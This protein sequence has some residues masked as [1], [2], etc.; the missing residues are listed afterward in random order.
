MTTL[1]CTDCGFDASHWSD[2]DLGRTLAHADD[3]I[4]YVLEGADER[5]AADVGAMPV[6][7]SGDPITSAHAVMHRLHEAAAVR[8]VDGNFEPMVGRVA[9]LQASGGGVPKA[10]IAV[11]DI[12][13]QGVGGDVQSNRLHHGRPWQAVCLYS[14]DL[15]AALRDEGHPI[16]PGGAGENITISGV[17]WSRLRGGLTI[18]V[19]EVVLITSSPAAPCRK[20][21]DCF[22]ER[23]WNR[24]DHGEHPGWARWYASVLT[25]GT[26]RPGDTVTVTA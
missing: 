25:G 14:A 22:T 1:T 26:I 18:A 13:A 9:S 2:D 3:L 8:R 24:I 19:G 11:A 23:H 4:G 7:D 17:D 15:I 21:G 12:G 6:V 16:T 5:V 20:I 10:S